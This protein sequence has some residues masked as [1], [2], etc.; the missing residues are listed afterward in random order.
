MFVVRKEGL[1]YCAK[2]SEPIV[3]VHGQQ[4]IGKKDDKIIV[5]I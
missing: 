5:C 1:R 3:K 2:L 4:D